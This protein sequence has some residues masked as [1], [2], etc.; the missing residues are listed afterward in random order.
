M[1][2]LQ[3]IHKPRIV[4]NMLHCFLQKEQGEVK[5]FS[6]IFTIH[7]IRRAN[8]HK[9]LSNH[10]SFNLGM[11]TANNKFSK[12]IKSM[13][14]TYYN[15]GYLMQTKSHETRG[16]CINIFVWHVLQTMVKHFHMQ[17]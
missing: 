12:V 8:A 7:R 14:C 11:P 2:R 1:D 17:K 10:H 5:D 16:S 3:S 4:C 13:P 15:H 9:H 6:D